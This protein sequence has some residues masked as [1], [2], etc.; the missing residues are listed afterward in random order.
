MYGDR[1]QENVSTAVVIALWC[2]TLLENSKH[3]QELTCVTGST[4]CKLI[5]LLVQ[6]EI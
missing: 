3:K 6:E 1:D 5:I 2:V 4:R